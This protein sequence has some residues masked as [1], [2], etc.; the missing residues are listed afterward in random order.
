MT[1][2]YYIDQKLGYYAQY[3]IQ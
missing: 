1:V 2:V 3:E